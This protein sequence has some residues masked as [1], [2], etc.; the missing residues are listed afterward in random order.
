[1]VK[2]EDQIV[3]NEGEKGATLVMALLMTSLLLTGCIALLTGASLTA[4]NA[5]D[6]VAEQQ[7]YNAAESGIQTAINVLRRNTTPNVLI[8]SSR[9]ANHLNNKIDFARAIE[10]STSNAPTDTS[11]DPRLSRWLNYDYTP[12]GATIPDRV[13]LTPNYNPQ[14]GSAFSITVHDPD[15]PAKI[16]DITTSA[17]IGGGGDSK[18]FLGAPGLATIKYNSVTTGNV[19]VSARDIGIN[20][21]SFTFSSFLAGGTV[22]ADTPFVITVKMTAPFPALI[23]VRGV[24]KAGTITNSSVG[25]VKIVFDSPVS[26]LAGSLISLPLTTITPNPPNVNGGKIDLSVKIT[27]AQPRRLVIR[28]IGYGPRGARKVFEAIVKRDNFDGLLPATVNLVGSIT[29]SLFKSSTASTQEVV[30]SGS[31]ASSAAKIPPIGTINSGSGGLLTN[32]LGS[33][34]GA[35]CVNCAVNG[36]PA[37]VETDETPDFLKTSTNLNNYINEQREL[38]KASGRY[39]SGGAIPDGFGDNAQGTGITFID[40]NAKFGGTSNGGSSGGGLL[41]VTGKLTLDSAFD[42]NGVILVTGPDGVLRNGG[43]TGNL[44]GNLIVA[45]Y[46]LSNVAAGFLPPK[47]DITGGTASRILYSATNLLFGSNNYNTVLV[48]VGEKSENF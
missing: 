46:N 23:K 7:A 31:E 40:G 32:L 42:F 44:Q 29:G 22:T 3:K 4:A 26:N 48:S 28:S 45:P 21:G 41:I 38:A 25:N 9:P 19:N 33:L 18:T 35:L 15:N 1:M 10:L 43:G 36:K 6:A 34:T 14:T 47:Y 27:L 13:S 11:T 37:D 16:I 20:L 39:Y 30:Y 17:S 2:P 12:A 8:D 5:T 24:I